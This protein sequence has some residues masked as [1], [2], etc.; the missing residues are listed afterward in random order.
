[1]PKV[2]LFGTYENNSFIFR[3]NIALQHRTAHITTETEVRRGPFWYCDART[4]HRAPSVV[5]SGMS[6]NIQVNEVLSPED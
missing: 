4:E 5:P 2:P 3:S 6:F 1:M